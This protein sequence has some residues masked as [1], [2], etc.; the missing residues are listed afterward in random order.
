MSEIN[1]KEDNLARKSK[2]IKPFIDICGKVYPFGEVDE[3]GVYKIM[4]DDVMDGEHGG[5]MMKP[6]YGVSVSTYYNDYLATVR[7]DEN[8]RDA[9]VKLVGAIRGWNTEKDDD[10]KEI[11]NYLSKYDY[12]EFTCSAKYKKGKMKEGIDKM[13]SEL[14]NELSEEYGID[15]D[16]Y[17]TID[18]SKLYKSEDMLRNEV[19]EKKDYSYVS[20]R[21]MIFIGEAPHMDD[22][23]NWVTYNDVPKFS[24]GAFA[25]AHFIDKDETKPHFIRI[26][27]EEFAEEERRKKMIHEDNRW[28][29]LQEALDESFGK[30]FKMIWHVFKKKW[31][32]FS[33]Y[34]MRY[35]GNHATAVTFFPKWLFCN[36][37]YMVQYVYEHDRSEKHFVAECG[38]WNYWLFLKEKNK[39]CWRTNKTYNDHTGCSL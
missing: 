35:V 16:K 22:D 17:L 39:W 1:L 2:E 4:Y 38:E 25:G 20:K 3:D 29:E 18:L 37:M 34:I 26:I 5:Y 19:G 14:R 30:A 6:I 12:I 8:N 28:R 33:P 36:K 7:F 11:D 27:V 31:K 15:S 32:K 21:Y 24:V 10:R 23:G 13:L 9:A